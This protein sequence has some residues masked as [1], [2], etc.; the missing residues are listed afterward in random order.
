MTLVAEGMPLAPQTPSNMCGWHED[1]IHNPSKGIAFIKTC[2][3]F[4]HIEHIVK[5]KK[6]FSPSL[7]LTC[8]IIKL[9]LLCRRKNFGYFFFHI[10]RKR[11]DQIAQRKKEQYKIYKFRK[12]KTK[13]QQTDW[14]LASR[15]LSLLRWVWWLHPLST[16][17]LK[18]FEASGMWNLTSSSLFIVQHLGN[19]HLFLFFFFFYPTL[20]IAHIAVPWSLKA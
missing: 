6:S 8:F 18:P 10:D 16:V 19:K 11:L 20:N 3:V 14:V 12:R 9:L 13:I 4:F 17:E 5:K 1:G 15:L 7:D 2:Y